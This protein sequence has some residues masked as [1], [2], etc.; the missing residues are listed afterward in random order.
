MRRK[1]K[2]V[3]KSYC[4]PV[5]YKGVFVS[6]K[7]RKTP[8]MAKERRTAG[9]PSDLNVKYFKAGGSTGEPFQIL[10]TNWIENW[11][12]WHASKNWKLLKFQTQ[13]LLWYWN[14]S[15]QNF[16]GCPLVVGFILGNVF[17]NSSEKWFLKTI[18][19][20]FVE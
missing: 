2:K 4:S 7:P 13:N 12:Q 19:Q 6:L 9:A 10:K 17:K 1:R 5:A 15:L 14:Q 8:C 20:Y 3:T 11:L 16:K 18:L